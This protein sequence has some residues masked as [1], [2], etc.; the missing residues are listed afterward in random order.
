MLRWLRTEMEMARRGTI[1]NRDMKARMA[2]TSRQRSCQKAARAF[3][4]MADAYRAPECLLSFI[5]V[6]IK[7]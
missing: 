5:F 6:V 1:A 2:A 7:H 4:K 3:M